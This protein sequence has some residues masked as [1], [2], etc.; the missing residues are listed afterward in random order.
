MFL[1]VGFIVY[2]EQKIRS[3]TQQV[4]AMH[5]WIKVKFL[6][7]SRNCSSMEL[8]HHCGCS[9]FIILLLNTRRQHIVCQGRELEH[10]FQL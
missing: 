4:M 2:Q 5:L 8:Y 6:D 9:C 7:M 10:H 3:L 1:H